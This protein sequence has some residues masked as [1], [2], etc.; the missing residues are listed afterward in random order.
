LSGAIMAF[1]LF[2][3]LFPKKF[4]GIDIGISSIKLVEISKWGG[5][6]TLENYGL[7]EA[8]ALFK[9]KIRTFE[10]TTL[11]VSPTYVS[12]AIKAVIKEAKIKTKAAIFSIPDFST[13]FIT[14]E[15]P[16]MEEKEISEAVRYNAPQYLP[17]P[18][19]ETTLDWRLVEGRPTLAEE[20]RTKLKI[21]VIAIPNEII[22]QYQMV[23]KMANLEL[24]A[25]ESEV[26]GIVKS[27]IKEEEKEGVIC[28]ID[29]GAHS[30]TVN[31]VDKGTLK[32]SYSLDFSSNNLTYVI[33]KSLEVEYAQAEILKK[34]YGLLPSK[35]NIAEILYPFLDPFLGE[36]RNI[37]HDFRESEE[38]EVEKVLLVGGG[39]KLPGLK[40]YFS[41]VL[42]K[43]VEIS[44]P[45]A[46]L[47]YPPVLG[48][49]LREL[50]PVFAPAIGVA[51]EELD[52]VD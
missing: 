16:P 4:L 25:L 49:I 41:E 40:T 31:I 29:L 46:D 20:G 37:F 22:A 10:E 30:S 48:E 18:I 33:T 9:E 7:I 27:S 34:K 14:L 35:E 50:G 8:K 3:K 19:S 6:R 38:K 44:N 51:L 26:F 32:K 42:K 11:L 23:A 28:L 36:V 12:R 15:L 13:F 52:R 39:A 2:E 1:K 47:F 17:L 24:Y 45:F 43:E 21:L 5:G